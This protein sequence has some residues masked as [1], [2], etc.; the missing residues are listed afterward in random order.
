MASAKMLPVGIIPV[1]I[2]DGMADHLLDLLPFALRKKR[3]EPKNDFRVLFNGPAQPVRIVDDDCSEDEGDGG[4]QA[5]FHCKGRSR[6][7]ARSRT[8]NASSA[9]R[10]Q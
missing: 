5:E 9:S 10:P 1:R 6:R 8:P 3:L 7:R 2:S 4:K